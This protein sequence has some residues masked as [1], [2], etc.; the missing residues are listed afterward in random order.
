MK[1]NINKPP[2]WEMYFVIILAIIGALTV[3]I[4]LAWLTGYLYQLIF[5]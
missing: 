3:S 1:I 5:T 2:M 4:I